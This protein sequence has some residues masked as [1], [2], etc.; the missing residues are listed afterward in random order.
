MKEGKYVICYIHGYNGDAYGH[1]YR[2]I[3]EQIFSNPIYKD[4]VELLTVGYDL[5]TTSA[6]IIVN[7][8]KQY[9]YEEEV[10]IVIG[11][12]LGAFFAMFNKLPKL[13]FCPCL[14]PTNELWRI[15]AE[16]NISDQF[17]RLERILKEELP[18]KK[19]MIVAFF[20]TRDEVLGQ[21]YKRM[22]TEASKNP[23][24]NIETY[25]QEG[26]H[27][28]NESTS[29]TFIDFGLDRIF[30]FYFNEWFDEISSDTISQ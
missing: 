4:R 28:M 26:G 30:K 20:G 6:D 3:A 10:D 13:L 1:T 14:E 22:L 8:M 24:T 15:G 21:T 9:L 11:N 18:D 17:Y 7:R 16:Q 12:S 29:K 19:E 23:G 2:L 5:A 25:W 27:R